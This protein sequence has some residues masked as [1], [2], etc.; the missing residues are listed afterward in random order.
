MQDL[1]RTMY[2]KYAPNL[3]E[4]ELN[5]KVSYA[6]TQDKDTFVNA[7]YNKY[8]GSGPSKSQS[9]YLQHQ[10][11]IDDIRKDDDR[12]FGR[13][14]GERLMMDVHNKT[15][16]LIN[17]MEEVHGG[18]QD[19]ADQVRIWNDTGEWRGLTGDE[20][21]AK[22]IYRSY[23]SWQIIFAPQIL[24]KQYHNKYTKYYKI[25]ATLS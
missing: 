21:D 23:T 24:V 6:M 7:F 16:G 22:I 1:Y 25:I 17:I 18:M 19:V 4:E 15:A 10:F 3:S 2:L 13:K 20:K 9:Q 14:I 12:S 5:Q 8:T 11:E